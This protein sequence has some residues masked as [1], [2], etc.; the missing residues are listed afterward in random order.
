[1]T[2]GNGECLL[3]V[4][5][6]ATGCAGLG[7]RPVSGDHS[8]RWKEGEKEAVTAGSWE[9]RAGTKHGG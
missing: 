6:R 1:M 2:K 3:W 5:S 4:T 9:G 7:Q 8:S